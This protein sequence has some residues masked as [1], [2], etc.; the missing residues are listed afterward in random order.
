MAETT[1]ALFPTCFTVHFLTIRCQYHARILSPRGF[2]NPLSASTGAR[3]LFA[4]ASA[5]LHLLGTMTERGVALFLFAHQ[6]ACPYRVD[7]CMHSLYQ[8]TK[9]LCSFSRVAPTPIPRKRPL[10]SDSPSPSSLSYWLTRFSLALHSPHQAQFSTPDRVEL[11][12]GP[13]P[14]P[15]APAAQEAEIAKQ[16]SKE[17]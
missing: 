12:L 11:T 9:S 17:R 1:P 3:A 6:P 7:Q 13:A 8:C 2:A 5:E 16:W 10:T 4:A 15:L 14:R